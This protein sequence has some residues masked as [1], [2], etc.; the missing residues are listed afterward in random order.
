MTAV[1]YFPF[2]HIN[3][4]HVKT[5]HDASNM[6]A[7]TRENISC[8]EPHILL[9]KTSPIEFQNSSIY[10]IKPRAF[11]NG[12]IIVLA[13]IV[14]SHVNSKISRISKLKL[15]CLQLAATKFAKGKWVPSTL[16][17]GEPS[18]RGWRTLGEW[19]FSFCMLHNTCIYWVLS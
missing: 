16:G 12:L 13:F 11:E 8:S 3:S 6:L 4:G 2:F 15:F 10:K 18:D 7:S 14:T 1:F 17:F 19:I 5:D 9:H